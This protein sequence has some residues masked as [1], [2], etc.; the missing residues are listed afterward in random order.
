MG[1]Q[2]QSFIGAKWLCRMLT[3][4]PKSLQRGLALRLIAASPHYFFKEIN[5][6]YKKMSRIEFLEAEYK[7]LKVSR[8]KMYDQILKP[9]LDDKMTVMDYGCGPG[10]LAHVVSGAVSDVIAVDISYGVLKCAEIINQEKNIKYLHVDQLSENVEDF[11]VDVIYS[12]AVVQHLTAEAFDNVLAQCVKKLKPKGKMII[13]VQSQASGWT[14]EE[15]WRLDHSLR[16]RIK[17][18]YGLHCFSRSREFFEGVFKKF[19]LEIK[20][21]QNIECIVKEV[22]DDVCKQDLITAVKQ[23]Q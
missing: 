8:R 2:P 13:Q 5:P 10:F 11:S 23:N 12:F 19:G 3:F 22:F 4:C 7:R 15:K 18:K 14:T 20:R 16:G 21:I 6:E 1:S 17:L 9:H